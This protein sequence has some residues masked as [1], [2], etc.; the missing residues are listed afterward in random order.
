MLICGGTISRGLAY[1]RSPS[2]LYWISSSTSLRNTTAPC[3]VARLRPISKA[4]LF[5]WLGMPPLCTRSSSRWRTPLSRLIPPVLNSS[6]TA[7]GLIRLLSG[8][9]RWTSLR[10]GSSF[11]RNMM[12]PPMA[13]PATSQT[14]PG[15]PFFAAGAW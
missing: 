13:R 5:T 2:G 15:T 6:F 4:V 10:P 12:K 9:S 7:S 11:I 8:R 1:W 14:Q 3:V